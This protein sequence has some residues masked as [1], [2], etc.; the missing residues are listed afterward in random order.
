MTEFV[1]DQAL[2]VLVAGHEVGAAPEAGPAVESEKAHERAEPEGGGFNG[3]GAGVVNPSTLPSE[4]I[5]PNHTES[6][7]EFTFD[8]PDFEKSLP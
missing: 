1:P 6:L 4:R 2:V 3:H 5:F 8:P 7:I